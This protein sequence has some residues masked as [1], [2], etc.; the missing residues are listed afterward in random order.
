M[1]NNFFYYL[2]PFLAP[3]GGLFGRLLS[4]D[5]L[6][7]AVFGIAVERIKYEKDLCCQ[8]IE[9]EIFFNNKLCS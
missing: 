2:I 6:P 9:G 5:G 4:F 3:P 8:N 1:R 7:E